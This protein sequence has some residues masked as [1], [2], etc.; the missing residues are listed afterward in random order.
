MSILRPALATLLLAA[1]PAAAF[2]TGVAD[3]RYGSLSGDPG[4]FSAARLNGEGALD[5][6]TWGLQLGATLAHLTDAD[7]NTARALVFR[8]IG[9][10]VRLGIST[11]RSSFDGAEGNTTDISIHALWT[12]PGARIDASLALPDHVDDTGAFSY[13]ISGVQS[14]GRGLAVT[15]D[16]Y[17]L[18]TDLELD[19]FWSIT[20][21]LRYDAT[22][23]MTLT[24]AGIRSTADDYNFDN[25][26]ARLGL[27]WRLTDTAVAS[28]ALLHLVTADDG[29]QTG[30]EIRLRRNFGAPVDT[31]RLFDAGPL[32]DRLAIGAFEP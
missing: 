9:P 1:G 7:Q 23:R 14:L 26:M 25:R 6:G 16:L 10:R 11:G 3:L 19:D 29:T 27:D 32:T 30:L 12:A 21:G 13:D 18:S 28:A 24:A 2:D 5:F 31:S 20:I 4:T 15:T 22:E 17:R 8:D